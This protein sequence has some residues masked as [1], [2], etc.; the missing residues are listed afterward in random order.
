MH[1]A[2]NEDQAMLRDAVAETLTDACTPDVLRAAWANPN[3]ALWS[4]MAELGIFGLSLPEDQG[5]MGLSAVEECAVA[6]EIGRAGFPGPFAET[7]AAAPFLSHD[8][9]LLEGVLAGTATIGLALEGHPVPNAAS[10]ARILQ[11]CDGQITTLTHADC[12]PVASIDPTR[13]LSRVIGG[14]SPWPGDGDRL[15]QRATLFTAAMLVGLSHR[16]LDLAVAYAKE[17]KQFGKAIGTFQAVQHRLADA[18]LALR[19][20][21]APVQRAAWAL[22]NN[23]DSA[24]IDVSTAKAMA[25]DAAD[26]VARA[27]LQVHGANG[28]T[29]EFDLHLFHKRVIVLQRAWGDARWHRA[30]VAKHLQL[31]S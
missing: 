23:A 31:D 11:I 19:F 16:M 20:A 1:F 12:I 28:Y 9:D 8:P 26:T 17:R 29:F 7:L 30:N 15:R 14:V 10:A 3:P 2:L 22:A 24:D 6:T 18:L 21:E 25:T 5:G 13:A 27:A 4:T